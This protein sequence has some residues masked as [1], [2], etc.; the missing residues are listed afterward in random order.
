LKQIDRKLKDKNAYQAVTRISQKLDALEVDIKQRTSQL[1]ANKTTNRAEVQSGGSI[2]VGAIDIVPSSFP[3]DRVTT[4]FNRA[5]LFTK[6]SDG[7]LYYQDLNG[8]ELK[9]N[10]QI[11]YK[12][13]RS[14]SFTH[15]SGSSDAQMIP[16]AG[17]SVTSSDT[18][19]TDLE[20]DDAYYIVPH[21]L[22]ITSI[23]GLFAKQS[24]GNVNPGNT[25][26]RLYNTGTELSNAIT[27]NI[28]SVG[29]DETNLFTKRYTWDFSQ[30]T[31]TY[32][33]GDIMHIAI[34]PTANIYYATLTVIGEYT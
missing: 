21:N 5:K 7:G 30:E 9:I 29:Y 23:K 15:G 12:W 22:K 1:N 3:N 2:E 14:S 13:E 16:L 17:G 8:A 33:A 19:P 25:T 18:T 31:N 20:I 34:D 6:K 24:S 32:S 27:V 11:V 10:N 4:S 28:D 26:M